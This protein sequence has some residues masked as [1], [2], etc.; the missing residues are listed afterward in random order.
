[1]GPMKRYSFCITSTAY[2]TDDTTS[3]H[4]DF[5][6]EF[7]LSPLPPPEVW[8]LFAIKSAA[9][10]RLG[11]FFQVTDVSYFEFRLLNLYIFSRRG[12]ERHEEGEFQHGSSSGEREQQ[13]NWQ[14]LYH[15]YGCRVWN[16][17]CPGYDDIV[18]GKTKPDGLR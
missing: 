15:M 6:P 18:E 14:D 8:D 7:L 1:M 17:G 9:V 16:V 10:H 5:K 4:R 12:R 2:A 13:P 11:C 3:V